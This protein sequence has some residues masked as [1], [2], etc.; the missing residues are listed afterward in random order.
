MRMQTVTILTDNLFLSHC[1]LTENKTKELQ[2][3]RKSTHCSER[4]YHGQ[5]LL[6]ETIIHARG[7]TKVKFWFLY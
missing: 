4:D 6:S 2:G 7:E 3:I 1:I 5:Q